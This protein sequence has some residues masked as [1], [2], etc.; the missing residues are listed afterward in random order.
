MG[1]LGASKTILIDVLV[2]R[3]TEGIIRGS[4][5]VNGRELLVSF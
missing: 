2:Q 5:L 4:I 3:K 1:L